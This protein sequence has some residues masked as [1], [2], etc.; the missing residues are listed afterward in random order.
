LAY[1]KLG[2]ESYYI[3]TNDKPWEKYEKAYRT[4]EGLA[5][6]KNKQGKRGFINKDK[7]EVIP[8]KYEDASSFR[9]GLAKVKFGGRWGFIDKDKNKKPVIP[10]KY[11]DA[12]SFSDGLAKVKLNGEWIWIN[13]KGNEYKTKA[14]AE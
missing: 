2:D 7:K 13:K 9:D 14:E 3:D 11:E 10:F 1:V 12:F 8:L 4:T 5:L 6:V